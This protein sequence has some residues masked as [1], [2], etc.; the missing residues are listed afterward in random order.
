MVEL[1]SN[2]ENELMEEDDITNIKHEQKQKWKRKKQK[3]TVIK[4]KL[5]EWMMKTFQR[6]KNLNENPASVAL[7]QQRR[8]AN[9]VESIGVNQS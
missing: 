9:V 1:A 3:G 8:V 2:I 6:R 5:G 7:K 4:Q